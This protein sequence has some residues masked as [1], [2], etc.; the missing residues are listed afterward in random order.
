MLRA[1]TNVAAV[2]PRSFAARSEESKV[3]ARAVL[4]QIGMYPLSE[5]QPGQRSFGYQ[6][7]ARKAIT[8]PESLRT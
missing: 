8:H 7:Q 6:A 4:D 5:D 3:T 2:L 1:P